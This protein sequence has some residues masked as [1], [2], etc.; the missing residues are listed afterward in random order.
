MPEASGQKRARK[1]NRKGALSSPAQKALKYRQ[2]M[3]RL[4]ALRQVKI[5]LEEGK[6]IPREAIALIAMFEI[7]LEEL[8]EMGSPYE[9]VRALETRHPLLFL[10]R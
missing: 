7:H 4:E 2:T 8:T 6:T 1:N 3:S 9:I 5:L 10:N